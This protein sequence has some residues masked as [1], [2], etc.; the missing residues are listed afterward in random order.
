MTTMAAQEQLLLEMINRAR[1]DPNGEAARLG[2]T[3][4]EGLAAGTISADAKQPLAGNNQLARAAEG[5]SNAMQASHVLD[6]APGPNWRN[7]H[8]QAGDGTPGERI[9]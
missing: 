1:L 6:D 3:L 2:I 4:N 9:A 7:P 5:H 8:T